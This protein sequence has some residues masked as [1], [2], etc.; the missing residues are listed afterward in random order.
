MT[1]TLAHLVIFLS[2][3]S[4]A[5][6]Q[7][8]KPGVDPCSLLTGADIKEVTALDSPGGKPNKSNATVCDYT[9]GTGGVLGV[10][11]PPAGSDASADRIAAE[12][13][14]RGIKTEIAA[15]IGD[16]AF[17]AA[18]GYGMTQLNA[19]KGKSYVIITLMLPGASEAK[20]KDAAAK[21]MAK[22]LAKL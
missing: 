5:L 1:R 8:P 2:V 9:V 16:R 22:A 14:K 13:N 6:A 4:A 3:S 18:M 12:L 15:G 10:S 19:F 21:L 7:P 17:Y 20:N 11:V